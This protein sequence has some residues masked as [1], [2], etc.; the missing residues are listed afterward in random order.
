[1]P[2][3]ASPANTT[4]FQSN[5]RSSFQA[6]AVVK[7]SKAQLGCVSLRWRFSPWPAGIVLLD[8]SH[9]SCGQEPDSHHSQESGIVAAAREQRIPA[10]PTRCLD[11]INPTVGTVERENLSCANGS[12]GIVPIRPSRLTCSHLCR[13]MLSFPIH[14]PPLPVWDS[15]IA[16]FATTDAEHEKAQA[17]LA[18]ESKSLQRRLANAMKTNLWSITVIVF[19]WSGDCPFGTPQN[20]CGGLEVRDGCWVPAET[21]GSQ[22]ALLTHLNS[23]HPTCRVLQVE[24]TNGNSQHKDIQYWD[25][26]RLKATVVGLYAYPPWAFAFAP[27]ARPNI[28]WETAVHALYSRALDQNCQ[29]GTISAAER[30]ERLANGLSPPSSGI[31]IRPVPSSSFQAHV[32]LLY[33]GLSPSESMAVAPAPSVETM[34]GDMD[35]IDES[36]RLSTPPPILLVTT[37]SVTSVAPSAAL[38]FDEG[39]TPDPQSLTK[40][41]TFAGE[42]LPSVPSSSSRVPSPAPSSGPDTTASSPLSSV[43]A[44][45][46]SSPASGK[47]RCPDH[48]VVDTF[49]DLW[50]QEFDAKYGAKCKHATELL[51]TVQ[52]LATRLGL[53]ETHTPNSNLAGQ[54]D[55]QI[56]TFSGP[57]A[58]RSDLLRCLCA[59]HHHIHCQPTPC[60][61]K[62]SCFP[63]SKKVA[64]QLTTAFAH[65]EE[66]ADL[67]QRIQAKFGSAD[68]QLA[69]HTFF[70]RVLR[71]PVG[72]KGLK[73]SEAER[74]KAS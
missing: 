48:N 23:M 54:S 42:R 47:E 18:E 22:A 49:P 31:H 65:G 11:V 12:F 7:V 10:G 69:V 33:G 28:T 17:F 4:K 61:G 30:E 37:N 68:N 43:P 46:S 40:H 71:L 67:I 70:R 15:T 59:L 8:V 34:R 55:R 50:V 14:L 16:P 21:Y 13:K 3:S 6:P 35:E 19:P 1:M 66:Q 72:P 5:C 62:A 58:S 38:E 2:Q 73:D 32:N 60:H 27:V 20:A 41:I 45:R 64:L 74:L 52:D 39:S 26:L 56:K 25:L 53:P 57:I 9:R 36:S 44:S 24:T 51:S 63:L 29:E